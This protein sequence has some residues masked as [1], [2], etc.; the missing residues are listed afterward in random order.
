MN[1]SMKLLVN[2]FHVNPGLTR[3]HTHTKKNPCQKR[4]SLS[5]VFFNVKHWYSS[6]AQQWNGK[7]FEHRDNLLTTLNTSTSHRIW[8]AYMN[9]TFCHAIILKKIEWQIRGVEQV[10][11]ITVIPI[12]LCHIWTRHLPPSLVW[13]GASHSTSLCHRFY[14]Y[15]MILNTVLGHLVHHNC[16]IKDYHYYCYFNEHNYNNWGNLMEWDD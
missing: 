9:D 11:V 16:L 15:R 7:F 2:T 3:P 12:L 14:I 13:C 10:W 6:Q 1:L 8:F 4:T 5:M